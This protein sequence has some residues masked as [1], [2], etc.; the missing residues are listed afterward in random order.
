MALGASGAASAMKSKSDGGEPASNVELGDSGSTAPSQKD[1]PPSGAEVDLG[2]SGNEA[3]VDEN[4]E[5]IEDQGLS[6]PHT[7]VIEDDEQTIVADDSV[8]YEDKNAVAEVAHAK[9]WRLAK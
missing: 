2:A 9:T 8:V 1:L 5:V 7:E 4:T 6:D 3:L